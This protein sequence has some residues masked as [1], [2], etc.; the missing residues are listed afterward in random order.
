MP[1]AVGERSNTLKLVAMMEAVNEDGRMGQEMRSTAN[2]NCIAQLSL[3][4]LAWVAALALLPIS[5]SAAEQAEAQPLAVPNT[6]VTIYGP[7]YVLENFVHREGPHLLFTDRHGRSWPLVEET[8]SE[9]ISNKGDGDFHAFNPKDVAG[10]INAISYPLNNLSV[11]IFVLPLPRETLLDCSAEDGAI[12][13]SPGVYEVPEGHTHMVVTHEMGH[14][15]HRALMP[16][17]DRDGWGRYKKIRGIDNMAVYSASAQHRNRPNEIFAEDFRWLFGGALSNYSGTIENQELEPPDAVHGLAEFMLSLAEVRLARAERSGSEAGI[18]IINY[19]NPF[20]NV[21]TVSLR[22][23]GVMGSSGYTWEATS[24]HA[25][26]FDARGRA[27]RDLGRSSVNGGA[28]INFRWDGTD[29]SGRN[30]SSGVY[31]LK[32]D[33]DG[34]GLS[35]T[36]KMLLR[37]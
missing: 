16:D 9:V 26:V 36:H 32:V 28:S 35:S 19:P 11:E 5:V 13:L 4:G 31:F 21:T 25:Q 27:V 14:C 33:L 7:D 12:Y 1:L 15:V 10:A 2:H 22:P 24:A 8:S 23:A 17:N 18:E 6:R 29:G 34:G 3:A 37:R 30:M 20:S